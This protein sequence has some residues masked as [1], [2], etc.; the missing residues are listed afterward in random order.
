MPSKKATVLEDKE[1]YVRKAD[2][3]NMLEAQDA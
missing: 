1:E 3:E 2:L